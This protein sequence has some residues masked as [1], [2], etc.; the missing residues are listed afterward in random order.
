MDIVL[1]QEINLSEVLR[2]AKPQGIIHAGAY[3]GGCSKIYDQFPIKNRCWIE[4]DPESYNKLVA[5][6]P[7]SDVKLNVAV[8]DRDG[9][10]LFLVTSNGGSSSLLPLKKHRVRYPS[11][12]VK[13]QIIVPCRRLDTLVDQGLIDMYKYNFLLMD[14]QGAEYLALKGFEKNINKIGFIVA[15]INYEELYEGCMLAEDFDEYLLKLG[16]VK[17]MATKYENLGWGDAYY[18]RKRKRT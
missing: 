15:E 14:L 18:K 10:A 9:S 16:F 5:N 2:D 11:I 8:S 12:V 1:N 4:A 13:K 17:I 7:D 3:I 6:V